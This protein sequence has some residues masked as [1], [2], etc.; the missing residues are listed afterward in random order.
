M[1]DQG[2]RVAGRGD[3]EV[4]WSIS[5]SRNPCE[6]DGLA[7]RVFSNRS[8]IGNRVDRG[9]IADRDREGPCER[10]VIKS[11]RLAV[12]AGVSD[13]HRDVDRA[14]FPLNGNERD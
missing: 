7:A 8:R 9:I 4:L 3:R 6:V 14:G 11:A 1:R 2:R 13:G 10:A 5:T 12:I